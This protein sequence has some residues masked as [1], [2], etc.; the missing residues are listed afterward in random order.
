M[1]PDNLTPPAAAPDRS[2]SANGLSRRR[3]LQARV[4]AGGGLLLSVSLPYANGDAGAADAEGFAPTGVAP[5]ASIVVISD[6]PMLS[7][8]V[9]QDRTATPST[10]TVQAPQSAMPQ[11]AVPSC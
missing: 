5:I 9:M 10:C 8:G 4:A 1:I 2:P 7:T 3:L 6:F 11:P